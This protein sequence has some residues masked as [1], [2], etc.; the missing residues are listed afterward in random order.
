[1]ADAPV[2][3]T[4]GK[5]KEDYKIV[6]IE[7]TKQDALFPIDIIETYPN[8][9]NSMDMQCIGAGRDG[10]DYAIK[11]VLDGKGYVPAT[12]LFCYEL[13]H[14]VFIPTPEYALVK[15]SDDSIAFGSVWNGG[16][17][18]ITS[19]MEA[20]TFI[21]SKNP[22]DRIFSM[23]SKIYGLDL[24][25]NNIDRHFGNYLFADSYKRRI[26]LAFDFSRAWLEVDYKGVDATNPSPK[27]KTELCRNLLKMKGLLKT[28]ITIETLESIRK[29]DSSRIKA[30]FNK[31]PQK[32]LS[33][34]FEAEFINWWGGKDFT[35]RVELLKIEAAK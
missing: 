19:D 3:N 24:F 13:A 31:M 35:Q 25:V 15:M 7:Q 11:T 21:N 26:V 9:Q 1:M 23:V 10:R 17:S 28:D 32:W 30:I 5:D 14:C 6:R 22:D 2:Q 34:G 8:D 18:T 33:S 4:T 16:S 20:M 29:I 27:N 12:E